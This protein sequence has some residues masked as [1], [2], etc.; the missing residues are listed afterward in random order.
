MLETFLDLSPL[1]RFRSLQHIIEQDYDDQLLKLCPLYFLTTN[2]EDRNV[3]FSYNSLKPFILIVMAL[4]SFDKA[5]YSTF[6]YDKH[7]YILGDE[8]INYLVKEANLIQHIE[9]KLELKQYLEIITTIGFI[10]RFNVARKFGY[11]ERSVMQLRLNS[12]GRYLV[13]LYDFESSD[14]FKKSFS[15]LSSMLKMHKNDYELIMKLC[16]SSERPLNVSEIHKINMKIPVPV[17]T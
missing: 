12:W 7:I 4:H 2:P 3:D 10:Y 16:N 5:V 17:V 8:T 15:N 14:F 11:A 6:N 1:E 9:N 13:E